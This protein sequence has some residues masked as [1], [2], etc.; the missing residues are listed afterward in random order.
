MCNLIDANSTCSY[1][2][3]TCKQCCCLNELVYIHMHLTSQKHQA[4]LLGLGLLCIKITISLLTTKLSRISQRH[5]LSCRGER[6]DGRVVEVHDG[7]GAAAAAVVGPAARRRRPPGPG[8]GRLPG[9]VRRAA[10]HRAPPQLRRR[11]GRLP[12][13]GGPPVHE[14][15]RRRGLLPPAVRR[16][17]RGCRAHGAGLL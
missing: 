17:T 6:I 4:F 10:A 13:P 12:L 16:R 2:F 7:L 15:R 3:C 11:G 8:A 5:T 9:R 1:C 14:L